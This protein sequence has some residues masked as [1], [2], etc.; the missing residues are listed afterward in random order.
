[1]D[2]NKKMALLGSAPMPKALL[3]L[4]VPTMAGML[5]NALYNLVD[6]YFAGGLGTGQMGAV[7]VAFPLGQIVV[8]LGL[9]FGN[10]AAAYLSRLLGQ[11][12]TDKANKV[13]STALYSG[14]SIGAVVILFSLDRKSVV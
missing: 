11:G 1:M 7:T 13:A 2:G 9:L 8:G 12:D 14:V 3:A 5:V 10:G 4:G 6:T